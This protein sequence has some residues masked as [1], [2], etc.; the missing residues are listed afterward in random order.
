MRSR[1][2]SATAGVGAELGVRR[3][4]M[5][6]VR[7]AT[8]LARTCGR[9]IGSPGPRAAPNT[10]ERSEMMLARSMSRKL[11][12]FEAL[13]ACVG[14]VSDA[15]V[16]DGVSVVCEDARGGGGG[17]GGM[18]AVDGFAAAGSGSVGC[19]DSPCCCCCGGGVGDE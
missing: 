10:A 11:P 12:V 4:R 8:D 3:S 7:P 19:W 17:G 6:T 5:K 18:L 2:R 9:C 13:Y 15:D 14:F 16:V 1:T